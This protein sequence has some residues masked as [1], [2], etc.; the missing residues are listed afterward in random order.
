VRS[1]AAPRGGSVRDVQ[2]DG[3]TAGGSP[4]PSGVYFCRVST[5]VGQGVRRIVLLR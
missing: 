4:A 3:R 1:F 5:P 2:W